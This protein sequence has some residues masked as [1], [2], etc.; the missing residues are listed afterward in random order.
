MLVRRR[1]Q[2]S[3]VG[4]MLLREGVASGELPAWLDVEGLALGY[5]ALLDGLLLQR[6]ER[7][8]GWRREDAER[9]AF[10]LLELLL[11]SSAAA[12]RPAIERPR[13]KPFSLLAHGSSNADLAS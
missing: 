6:I 12:G 9:R 5:S 10:A 7:A 13:A 8:D 2:I 11:A 1:E 4:Q 3:A